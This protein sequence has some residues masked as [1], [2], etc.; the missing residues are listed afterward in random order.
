MISDLSLQVPFKY[1]LLQVHFNFIALK[2]FFIIRHFSS[3]LNKEDH[4][5][6][7]HRLGEME[8]RRVGTRFIDREATEE[9][10]AKPLMAVVQEQMNECSLM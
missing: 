1:P 3:G 5:I 6:I 8:K 2:R 10:H 9:D 4:M 7:A